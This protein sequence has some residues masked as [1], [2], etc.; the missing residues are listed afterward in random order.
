LLAMGEQITKSGALKMSLSK[1]NTQNDPSGKR[2]NGTIK[3]EG[4]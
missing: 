1:L 2:F 4:N 3:Q